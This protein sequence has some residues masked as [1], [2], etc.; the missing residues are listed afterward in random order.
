[1]K[2]QQQVT[3]L[4]SAVGSPF[5]MVLGALLVPFF[6]GGAVDTVTGVGIVPA[7]ILAGALWFMATIG[8]GVRFGTW[9]TLF[10]ALVPGGVWTALLL[11]ASVIEAAFPPGEGI[12]GAVVMVAIATLIWLVGLAVG[13][14]MRKV[15]FRPSQLAE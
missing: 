8:L 10:L 3:W 4:I 15:I 7:G 1:M 13:V 11:V 6:V 14:L 5:G 9:R 12:E 2:L